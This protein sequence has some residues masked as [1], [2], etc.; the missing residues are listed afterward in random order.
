LSEDVL[1]NLFFSDHYSEY[2]NLWKQGGYQDMGELDV[3]AQIEFL[4]DE[5]IITTCSLNLLQSGFSKRAW[6]HLPKDTY[7]GNGRVRHEMLNLQVG[8]LAN[9]QVHSYQAYEI[10]ERNNE[11]MD[12]TDVGG[13]EHFDIHIFR[14][15]ELIGGKP[16]EIIK[17]KDL[18]SKALENASD[19]IGFNEHARH[20]LLK[21]FLNN[22]KSLSDLQSHK[23]TIT[24]M[25][26]LYKTIHLKRKGLPPFSEFTL[27]MQDDPSQLHRRLFMR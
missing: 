2:F 12:H 21:D 1:E 18:L 3:L 11:K 6:S 16:L 14:N 27:G 7:K 24:L 8:P 10:K 17:G 4:K 23:L 19:F 25:H 13:L 20:V 22:K 9:I 26:E 5:H 15:S